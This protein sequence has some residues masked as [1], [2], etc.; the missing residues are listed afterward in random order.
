MQIDEQFMTEVGLGQM[1]AAEKRA[2]MDHATEELE[3]RVGQKIGSQLSPSQINDFNRAAEAGTLGAWLERHI[4]D[5]RAQVKAV[6]QEFK[7]EL[8][9]E[10]QSILAA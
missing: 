2:F 4:P 7:R 8:H 1:P 3:V 10:R 6:F 9:A 5:Y